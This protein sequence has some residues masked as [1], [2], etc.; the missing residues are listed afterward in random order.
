MSYL[1]SILNES[2]R[3]YPAVPYNVRLA[4]RST[5]LPRGGGPDGTL[6]LAVLKDT[7]IGYSALYMQRRPELYPPVSE[8]FAPPHIFSPERWEHWHPKGHDYVPFNSG[9]RICV[10]QQFALTE[11]GYVLC[12]LFQRYERVESFADDGGKP[13]LKAEITLQPGNGVHVAFWEAKR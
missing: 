2:L 12:R 7:P 10:G 13:V 4:L 6:P 11:M 8:K 3:L 9:P 5:T 1:R